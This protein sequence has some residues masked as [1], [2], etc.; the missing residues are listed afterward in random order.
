VAVECSVE[1]A[2]WVVLERE[3]Q[4]QPAVVPVTSVALLMASY[5]EEVALSL[6]LLNNNDH[7]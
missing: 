6:A 3:A 5:V 1:M 4:L 7:E 2:L